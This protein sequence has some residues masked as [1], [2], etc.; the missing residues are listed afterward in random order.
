MVS[1]L[2]ETR[3][4]VRAREPNRERMGRILGVFETNVRRWVL[5]ENRSGRITIIEPG[6]K[7]GSGVVS[8]ISDGTLMIRDGETVREYRT[9]DS[10]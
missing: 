6:D 3:P 7:I 10:L 2:Q 9:G 4:Q 8:S 5:I 1:P